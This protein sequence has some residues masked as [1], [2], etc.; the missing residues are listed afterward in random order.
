MPLTPSPETVHTLLWT[1]GTYEVQRWQEDD[2]RCVQIVPNLADS[3]PIVA[4]VVE[5]LDE[6]IAALQAQRDWLGG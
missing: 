6:L 1:E 3:E 4:Y 2:Q 5:E